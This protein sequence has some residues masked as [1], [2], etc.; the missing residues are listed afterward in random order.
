MCGFRDQK[1]IIHEGSNIKQYIVHE[2]FKNSTKPDVNDIMLLIMKVPFN[3]V[4]T[5]PKLYGCES[6]FKNARTAN[7][8]GLTF[9]GISCANKQMDDGY[10]KTPKETTKVIAV[11]KFT[12]NGLYGSHT[13]CQRK[14]RKLTVNK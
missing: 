14:T 13:W 2:K 12:I 9:F 4:R 8:K 5:F 7:H 11:K 6:M 10:K 1:Q 3:H